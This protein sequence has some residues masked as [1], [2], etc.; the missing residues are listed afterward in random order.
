MSEVIL[1]LLSHGEGLAQAG[2][3][4][5]M[6]GEK[7]RRGRS[8]SVTNFSFCMLLIRV[9]KDFPKESLVLGPRSVPE[10]LPSPSPPQPHW[11]SPRRPSD[12]PGTF[13][14]QGSCTC[15]ALWLEPC[16]Q[17]PHDPSSPPGPFV[18]A[19]PPLTR[20]VCPGVGLLLQTSVLS[21]L[22]SVFGTAAGTCRHPESVRGEQRQQETRKGARLQS[23]CP[24]PLRPATS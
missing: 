23:R 10:A 17:I 2:Q 24:R 22:P 14:P 6:P 5:H 4:L 8:V 18:P 1:T 21:V 9:L 20:A 16:S 11:P 15:Q 7:P 12:T 3:A 13:W 19:A